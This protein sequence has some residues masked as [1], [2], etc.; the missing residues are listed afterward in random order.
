MEMT[1][2]Q[3][4][5]SKRL[6]LSEKARSS[7]AAASIR[8]QSHSQHTHS[9]KMQDTKHSTIRGRFHLQAI[10]VNKTTLVLS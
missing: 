10:E 4:A 7:T 3:E 2:C 9:K 1:S 8:W 5:S 6:Q